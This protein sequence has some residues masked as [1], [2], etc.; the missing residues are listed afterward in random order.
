[1]VPSRS[2]EGASASAWF[3]TIATSD[4]ESATTEIAAVIEAEPFEELDLRRGGMERDAIGSGD[5]HS[6]EVSGSNA[7]DVLCAIPWG[8]IQMHQPGGARNSCLTAEFCRRRSSQAKVG[9][10]EHHH[11]VHPLSQVSAIDQP[12][13]VV[14]ARTAPSPVHHGLAGH[15]QC[16]GTPPIKVEGIVEPQLPAGQRRFKKCGVAAG[17]AAKGE[18][19]LPA[20]ALSNHSPRCRELKKCGTKPLDAAIQNHLPL[21]HQQGTSPKHVGLLGQCCGFSRRHLHRVADT[22]GQRCTAPCH[23]QCCPRRDR[24]ALVEAGLIKALN[25]LAGANQEGLFLSTESS[26][27]RTP[28]LCVE[29]QA[30]LHISAVENVEPPS[31]SVVDD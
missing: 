9:R 15:N 12:K 16:G 7:D 26:V 14:N 8:Q 27:L 22:R 21:V 31:T 3:N 19:P 5:R 23:D 18:Q 13:T 30:A 2:A 28:G 11:E 6:S 29:A 10:H 24:H 17:A 20:G 4:Q 1:M 25:H